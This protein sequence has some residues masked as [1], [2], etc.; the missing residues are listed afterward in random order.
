M[1]QT[2]T[3]PQPSHDFSRAPL[4]RRFDTLR[5]PT[6]ASGT[7]SVRFSGIGPIPAPVH[8]LTGAYWGAAA[9]RL[10]ARGWVFAVHVSPTPRW[11]RRWYAASG[12]PPQSGPPPSPPL[13]IPH[14]PISRRFRP[15]PTLLESCGQQPNN[16]GG[17]GPGAQ[18]RRPGARPVVSAEALGAR[19]RS[20]A[21]V[22]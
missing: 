1:L 17:F 19:A 12:R 18:A 10:P 21:P 22:G 3:H 7:E 6:S 14:L 16:T 5:L 11:R 9:R 15:M 13:P 20:A 8:K 2:Q 4:H